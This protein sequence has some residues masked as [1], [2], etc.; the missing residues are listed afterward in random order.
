MSS[1]PVRQALTLAASGKAAEAVALLERA[2]AAQ[3]ADALFA[4]ALWRVDGRLVGRDLARA[5]VD[6]G[7]ADALGHRD[8][9]RVLGAFLATGIGGGA[10]WPGAVQ[11][12]ERWADRDT[13]A[14]RQLRLIAAMAL[15]ADGHPASTFEAD[16]LS[17]DPYVAIFPGLF[18]QAECRFLAEA[19]AARFRPATIFHEGQRRFVRDP[20]RN[21]DASSFSFVS[22]WPVVHALNRRLAAASGTRV[23]AA[24]TLQVLRYG[25]G[26]E[27]RPHLDAVPGMGNQRVLTFL[28]YL[29]GDYSG[30]ETLFSELGLSVAGRTG[31]GL[32]FANARPD[33]SPDPRT[34][35]SGAPVTAGTKL[36]ASRWIRAHPPQRP[37]EGFGRHEAERTQ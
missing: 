22:E 36:I 33:G 21:S 19:A 15:D 1:G 4:L 14:E 16:V 8:S 28:V 35:H 11:L 25:P 34:R 2:A 13:E 27:Y 9:A 7:Q 26:Q 10:D 6:L 3:D 29:N 20:L 5:R 24:E 23:D 31:L 12:L 30:G 17:D 37:D 18:T 32:L